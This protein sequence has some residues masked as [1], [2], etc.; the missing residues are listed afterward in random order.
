[1]TMTSA[2]WRWL[3]LLPIAS[4]TNSALSVAHGDFDGVGFPAAMLPMHVLANALEAVGWLVVL[5]LAGRR[6]ARPA[7]A[8]AFFLCGMFAFDLVTTWP[9]EMP[10][11][12]GFAVWGGIA[13]ALGLVAAAALQRS[14]E[15]RVTS[16]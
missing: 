14:A 7:A 6:A 13:L 16:R 1:M 15:H 5:V 4:F 2:R 9:L 10:I 11:P 3:L 8:L 12:P